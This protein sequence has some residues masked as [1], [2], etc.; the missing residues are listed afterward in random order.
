MVQVLRAFKRSFGS[1]KQVIIGIIFF[2]PLL[3]VFLG[4][5][6]ELLWGRTSYQGKK[7]APAWTLKELFIIS[8]KVLG[9]VLIYFICLTLLLWAVFR[10]MGLSYSVVYGVFLQPQITLLALLTTD[11]LS[12]YHMPSIIMLMLLGF[13]FNLLQAAI[14][15]VF[16]INNKFSKAFAFKDIFTIG[17]SKTY[18]LIW[19]AYLPFDYLLYAVDFFKAGSFVWFVIYGLV[20]GFVNYT[21]FTTFMTLQ[22]QA[23]KKLGYKPEKNR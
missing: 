1:L 8:M 23:I 19:L 15:L 9:F 18:F 7:K 10:L 17:F 2:H 11:S 14:S 5:G 6:Y 4:N 16:I 21:Y 20:I 13:V 22:G 3:I 12:Q